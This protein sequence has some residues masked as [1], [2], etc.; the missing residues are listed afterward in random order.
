MYSLQFYIFCYF[1]VWLIVEICFYFIWGKLIYFDA[2]LL[3]FNKAKDC[4]D[5]TWHGYHGD[6][7]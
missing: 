7:W 1:L 6:V 4:Y 5:G 3:L 2:H